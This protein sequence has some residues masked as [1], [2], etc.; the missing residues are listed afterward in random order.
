MCH[1]RDVV[2][3]AAITRQMCSERNVGIKIENFS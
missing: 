3:A 1:S 2:N